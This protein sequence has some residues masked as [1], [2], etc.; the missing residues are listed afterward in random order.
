M[1][2][3]DLPS[4]GDS[5]Q[6]DRVR[7]FQQFH[8]PA[9]PQIRHP[10]HYNHQYLQIPTCGRSIVS[11][12]TGKHP[13]KRGRSHSNFRA[14]LPRTGHRVHSLGAGPSVPPCLLAK[15]VARKSDARSKSTA[16]AVISSTGSTN[17][18][19]APRS[20]PSANRSRQ[21]TRGYLSAA[22]RREVLRLHLRLARKRKQG[23]VEATYVMANMQ[24]G[25]TEDDWWDC[26]YP[27]CSCPDG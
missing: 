24:L 4:S 25:V 22:K 27:P 20:R 17:G 14:T 8:S 15:I 18:V 7:L 6:G 26:M 12:E 1:K 11:V 21:N 16:F 3:G 9:A 13:R 2:S 10:A 19:V 5:F 23:S